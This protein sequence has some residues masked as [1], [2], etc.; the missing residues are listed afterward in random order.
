MSS[1]V[2]QDLLLV[3]LGRYSRPPYSAAV[4]GKGRVAQLVEQG[5]ENPRVGGSIPSPATNIKRSTVCCW[6]FFL[7]DRA[8]SRVLLGGAA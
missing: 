3:G 6:P 1:W 4:L 2:S 5:T 8:D 7:P